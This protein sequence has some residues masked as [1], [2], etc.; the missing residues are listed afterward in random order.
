MLR[1]EATVY[2]EGLACVVARDVVSRL[3][4]KGQL[5]PPRGYWDGRSQ[6]DPGAAADG[7]RLSRGTTRAVVVMEAVSEPGT[8]D[9]RNTRQRPIMDGGCSAV[10]GCLLQQSFPR[11]DL[12]STQQFLPGRKLAPRCRWCPAPA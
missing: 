6:S 4:N 9:S 8:R 12:F 2:A 1:N 10:S 7:H 5:L 3:K 11:R